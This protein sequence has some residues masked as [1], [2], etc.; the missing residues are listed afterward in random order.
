MNPGP[1]GDISVLE[2]NTKVRDLF[3]TVFP[4]PVWLRGSLSGRL[5]PGQSGHT[6]FQLLDETAGGGQAAASVDCVLFAGARS[7]VARDFARMGMLF[8]PEPGMSVRVLGR[9]DLWPRSGRFQFIVEAFDPYSFG[10]AS[11]LHLRAVVDRLAKEGLTTRNP[12]LPFPALPLRIGLISAPGSAALEDFLSTLRESGFPFEVVFHPAMMQGVTTGQSLLAALARLGRIDGLDAV[13]ITR[14]GGSAQDLAWFDSEPVG[15]A[16]AAFPVPVI[17]GIGHEIDFTV[18]DFVAHTRAKTPT[19][20]A[21]ILVDRVADAAQELD[22]A[23][24]ALGFSILPRL[25]AEMNRLESSAFMLLSG[26]AS[27]SRGVTGTLDRSLAWLGPAAERRIASADRRLS[28][29]SDG[30][31][32]RK[33]SGRLERAGIHLEDALSG[34]PEACGRRLREADR[35]IGILSASVEAREP[36][37][38]LALGW[39]V[40]SDEHGRILRSVEG[41][42]P[43]RVVRLRLSDGRITARTEAVERDDAAHAGPSSPGGSPGP[44]RS[45]G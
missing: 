6:Y 8:R 14:G 45:E 40:A 19:H 42:S 37:R 5:S 43:G 20:A 44:E 32:I 1:G 17:S 25:G 26:V 2:L 38:M 15:R 16:I 34:L 7:I 10:S 28:S 30:I 21:S 31:S 41:T 27:V 23:A 4:Y 3:Q 22:G 29:L 36:A 9:V 33:I 12:S 39:A 35:R 11:E 18:P 24:R 13:V